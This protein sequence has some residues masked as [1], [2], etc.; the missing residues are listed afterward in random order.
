MRRVFVALVACAVAVVLCGSLA[1]AKLEESKIRCATC[2]KA[3]SYVWQEGEALRRHCAD[4]ATDIRCEYNG[5]H[6]F[7]VEEMV[8]N[9]CDK[10]PR[11]HQAVTNDK[12]DFD[13]VPHDDPQHAKE[14]ADAIRKACHKWLHEEHGLDQVALYMYANL[15]AQKPTH[16]I[17]PG[18]QDRYCR[19]ACNPNHK[20]SQN[21][22]DPDLHDAHYR[23]NTDL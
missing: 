20:Q 1:T 8:S 6:H 5:I 9:V 21:V 4:E 14:D 15:D 7:G 13:L 17:L 12:D 23:R 19:A 10:L 11:K 16:M 3:I 22:H 18:L 2:R